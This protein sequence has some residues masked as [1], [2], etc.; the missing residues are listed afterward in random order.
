MKLKFTKMHGAGNDFVVLDG[1]RN[2]IS[3]T[4]ALVRYL[5]DRHFGIGAD[6]VLLVERPTINSVDFKYRIFNCD[7]REVEH[8]GNGARCFVK[9]VHETGLSYAHTIRV[10]VQHGVSTLS[11][12]ENGEVLVDMGSPGLTPVQ[13]PFDP[14]GLIPV[15][16]G[17]DLLWPLN[18]HGSTQWI[19]VVSMG[20]PHAVQIVHDINAAQV[21]RDGPFI[22]SQSN[23]PNQVNAG[24]MQIVSRH[25]IRLRV[26]ERGV[27][28]TLACGSGACAAVVAGI[29][30]RVLDSPVRVRT[31]GGGVL[32]ISWNSRH[33]NNNPSVMMAGPAS[34]VFKGEIDIP[35][36]FLV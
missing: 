26:Y 19:S 20:N 6:Q 14:S 30:R 21:L 9:F 2:I 31:R 34:T 18:V 33:A 16:D 15:S 25:E 17:D 4:P 5:A 1:V 12:Q 13:V 27:G 10:Q 22:E 7:G 28:E 35:N 32:T 24:F 3:P 8:C 11:L 36:C 23:F 29:R